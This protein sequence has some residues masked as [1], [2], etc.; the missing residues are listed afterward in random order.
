MAKVIVVGGGVAGM[1]AAIYARRAG[2]ECELF[3]AHS[4]MGGNL[5]AWRREGC[6]IDNCIHWLT[7]TRRGNDLNRVWHELGMLDG[8]TPVR[9]RTQLYESEHGGVRIGLGSDLEATR[10]Q[11]RALSPQDA[12][13]IN[14]LIDTVSALT[15]IVC[16]G[17]LNE[18]AGSILH[19]PDIVYYRKAT[20]FALAKRFRHPLLRLLLTDYI[21]GEFCALALLFAYA[22]FASGNG[23]VPVGGSLAAAERVRSTCEREGCI[24]HT[25][26]RVTQIT[27]DAT[28]ANGVILADGTAVFADYIIAACDPV[29]TFGTLLP[30]HLMPGALERRLY[31]PHTPIF[32]ALHTAFLCDRETLRPFGTRIIDSPAF[33]VRSGKRLPV[34]EFSHEPTFAPEGKV[35]LQTIVFQTAEESRAWIE[36]AEDR[37]R[38][39]ERKAS[40][41]DATARAIET[42]MPALRGHLALLDVW[43]P[44]TYHRYLGANKG[45]FLSYA[46]T[47]YAPLRSLPSRVST[48][49]N[50]SLATQWLSSPGGLPTAALAGRRAA[51]DAAV[52]LRTS[53]R[54]THGARGAVKLS[55]ES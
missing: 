28:E 30:R 36:L 40:V 45:A 9:R 46:F 54:T 35:V 16:N 15:P 18:K 12:R 10:R 29:V 6:V 34:R 2:L 31:N 23:S 27:T 41:A 20:L 42:A 43:T 50:L 39:R 5:T 25:G 48:I 4:I 47:P 51:H 49:K 14:R 3:E 52:A 37:Q 13:E 33:S 55:N 1:S 53:A 7:G 17:R 19:L 44:A 22:A 24:L 32:S 11:M 26:T 8:T 21:G 38:Y